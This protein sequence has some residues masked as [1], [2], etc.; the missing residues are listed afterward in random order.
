MEARIEQ[1]HALIPRNLQ[2]S[3]RDRASLNSS[4]DEYLI[5]KGGK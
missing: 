3:G 1:K 2:S 5:I 4:T